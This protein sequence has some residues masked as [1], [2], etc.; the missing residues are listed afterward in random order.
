MYMPVFTSN[1][2]ELW[3]SKI[4]LIFCHKDVFLSPPTVLLDLYFKELQNTGNTFSYYNTTMNLQCQQTLADQVFQLVISF[5]FLNR[6]QEFTIANNSVGLS[7]A[8][9]FQHEIR[10]IIQF[11]NFI[12]SLLRIQFEIFSSKN[13]NEK[14]HGHGR[15]VSA[16]CSLCISNQSLNSIIS[17]S[18]P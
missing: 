7:L 4:A 12:N 1:F 8:L 18:S 5:N 16:H 14:F 17:Y 10:I 6:V 9:N 13:R 2:T 3:A 11:N 15:S